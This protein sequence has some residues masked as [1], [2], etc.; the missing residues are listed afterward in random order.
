MLMQEEDAD[1]AMAAQ[2]AESDFL[3][4]ACWAHFY[5]TGEDLPIRVLLK[6]AAQRVELQEPDRERKERHVKRV[7]Q[8]AI[9]S[10]RSQPLEHLGLL[11]MY[12]NILKFDK[13][14]L[15]QK[16]K[17]MLLDQIITDVRDR[18]LKSS[19]EQTQTATAMAKAS[20][21][22]QSYLKLANLL[23]STPSQR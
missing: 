20:P 18:V 7:Q 15:K 9:N 5:A 10:L 1:T 13:S 16:S 8:H 12:E 3:V 21:H 17:M 2:F 6:I 11:P 23:A 14:M 22:F 4:D 19:P